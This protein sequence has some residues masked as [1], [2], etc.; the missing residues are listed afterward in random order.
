MFIGKGQIPLVRTYVPSLDDC[1]LL[2]PSQRCRLAQ[3]H[4]SNLLDLSRFR[5][6]LRA[7][8]KTSP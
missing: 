1:S 4:L 5:F 3:H 2:F 7:L 8:P 6:S